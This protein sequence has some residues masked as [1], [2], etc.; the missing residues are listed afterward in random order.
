MSSRPTFQRARKPDERAHRQ[1]A[2]LDAA[3]AL[4]DAEGLT[5]VTLNAVARRAGIAKSALYR[6][7]ESRE[8]M[9]L[10]LLAEAQAAATADVE[11]RLARLPQKTDP[12]A[13]ARAFAQSAVAA[14]RFCVLETAVVPQLEPNISEEGIARHKREVL[15]LGLRLGNALHAALPALPTQAIGPFLRYFH[16]IIAGLH[17]LAHP[18]PAAAQ[19]LR[20]PHFAPLRCDFAKDMEAMLA[21]VLAA[22]CQPQ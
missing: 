16:A 22:L 15:R 1:K 13:V 19:V 20:D 17:P 5:G 9:L 7:F 2:I 18:A 14:P 6:Y 10:A 11:Q 12:K 21:A 4:F 3:A 8:A